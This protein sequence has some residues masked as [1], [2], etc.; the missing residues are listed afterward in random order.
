M[1]SYSYLV[2]KQFKVNK[3]RNIFTITGLI[4]SIILIITVGYISNY[5]KDVDIEYAKRRAGNYEAIFRDVDVSEIDKVLYNVKVDNCGLYKSES[6]TKVNVGGIEKGFEIYSLDN[7][8]MKEIFNYMIVIS[9]GRLPNKPSEIALT[10]SMKKGIGKNIGDKLQ[11]GDKEY[12][13]VGF[14]KDDINAVS[15]NLTG[16][17]YLDVSNIN[18]NVNLIINVKDNGNKIENIKGIENLISFNSNESQGS[19]VRINNSV[20]QSDNIRFNTILLDAYGIYTTEY[21]K[22]INSKEFTATII[23]IVILLLTVLFTYGSIN[24]SL[25][26]RVRQFATLRCI[27]ATPNKI[28]YLLV[29]ES[30]LL[31]GC[32][33]V[34][35][36]ILGQLLSWFII[37]VAFIK[38]IGINTYGVGLRI[39]WS[40]ILTAIVFIGLTIIL[41]TIVPVLRINKISP[42][43]GVKS[44][45]TNMQKIKSRNSKLISSIFRYRGKLAFKNIAANSKSFYIITVSLIMILLVFNTFSGYYLFIKKQYEFEQGKA[46]DIASNYSYDS[47][48]GEDYLDEEGAIVKGRDIKS[49]L[50]SLNLTQ[51]LFMDVSLPV[52]MTFHGF[53]I[54]PKIKTTDSIYNDLTLGNEGS[55]SKL[56]VLKTILLVYDDES[57]E[58]II[59]YIEPNDSQKESITLD[60]FDENGFVIVKARYRNPVTPLIQTPDKEVR[61][62]FDSEES[63]SIK[64]D[65][66]GSVSHREL[67]SGKNF[68][69]YNDVTLIVSKDFYNA[70]KDKINVIE[71]HSTTISVN[72]NIKDSVDRYK[73]MANLQEVITMNGGHFIEEKANNDTFQNS[74]DAMSVL[75]YATLFLA[76]IIGGINIVNTRSINIILRK[77]EF[78]TLLAVGMSKEKVKKLIILEGIVQWFISGS[79]GTILSLILLKAINIMLVIGNGADMY[80]IPIWVI[81]IGLVI[82]L[83]INLLS[84]F[85]PYKKLKDLDVSELLRDDE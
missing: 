59:P 17:T 55:N 28:R 39:Y 15:F 26:E 29:K 34:P 24:V 30:F 31:G 48:V 32:S 56:E 45:I 70:N 27:G 10:Y 21:Y 22:M 33:I 80:P 63:K 1:K 7:I 4:S 49:E 9:E 19:N 13:I 16:I 20:N 12:T 42:V 78:G 36:V 53:T 50:K 46:F 76:M 71:Q 83:T 68:G 3:R 40:V 8:A 58:Q 44:H 37:E 69:R 57:L 74:L 73:A 14:Y 11:D 5:M 65:Y 6:E 61:L 43:Q 23:N 82:L 47:I 62:L 75:I 77:K 72:L 66:L 54:N 41:A 35:G 52:K 81:L 79:I 64:G 60:D 67:F 18:D 38:I 85:L 2:N 84:S 25:K 51:G